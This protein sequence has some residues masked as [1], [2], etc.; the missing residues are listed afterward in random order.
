MANTDYL[1]TAAKI[2]IDVRAHV[3]PTRRVII[4]NSAF[5]IAATRVEQLVTRCP[6]NDVTLQLQAMT[7][8][9]TV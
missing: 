5:S 7:E 6:Y 8:N 9:T 2:C 1:L 3:S 4:G